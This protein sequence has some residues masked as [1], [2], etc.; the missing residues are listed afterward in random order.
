MGLTFQ[1]KFYQV[2]EEVYLVQFLDPGDMDLAGAVVGIVEI[3]EDEKEDSKLNELFQSQGYYLYKINF[4][5]L[6]RE[7]YNIIKEMKE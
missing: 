7:G 3:L 1:Q 6:I 2:P 4:D 5:E